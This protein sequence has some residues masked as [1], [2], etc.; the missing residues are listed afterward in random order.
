MAI[1]VV[2]SEMSADN[3]YGQNG[4]HGPSSVCPG[5]AC[6]KSGFLPEVTVP[7]DKWQTRD[8]GKS[9]MAAKAPGA[10]K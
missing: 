2:G 7:D 8:V 6:G 10:K 9:G 4:Y 3:A 5:E 1:K